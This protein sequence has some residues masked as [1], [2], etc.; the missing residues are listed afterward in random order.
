MHIK[1]KFRLTYFVITSMLLVSCSTTI[2][3][4]TGTINLADNDA[5]VNTKL[6]FEK[7]NFIADK[8]IAIGQQ[9][10]TAYGMG[11]KASA[12]NPY[13]SDM[14]DVTGKYPAVQGWDVGHI[15]LGHS[16]NLDT[17][18]FDLMRRQIIEGNRRGAIT[19]ISWHVDN[20]ETDSVAWDPT[21]AV[22]GVLK[23][24]HNRDKYL[25]WVDRLSTFMQSLKDKDGQ[26]IPIIFRP[27]H[28]MN[29]SWFWWGAGNCTPKEYKALYRDLADLLKERGNHNLIYAYSPN[30]VKSVEE[31]ATY[32]PGDD[33]VDLMGIDLYNHRGDEYFTAELKEYLGY[34]RQFAEMHNKPYAM[35]ET[36]NNKPGDPNWWTEIFYPGIENSGIIYALFWRNAWPSHYFSTFSNE[37]SS[38]NFKVFEKK[39]EILFLEDIDQYHFK[40]K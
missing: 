30:T 21:P 16:I 29:G 15:E 36:G 19:T 33:Y 18:S 5:T 23:G 25:G 39:E 8:G 32:Y 17:V 4:A 27:Y 37:I 26:A 7:M 20:P 13:R 35:T 34:A 12:E 24:G 9:D 6:L 1:N 22:T 2:P 10:A 40:A 31:Y 38:E 3:V 14:H 11:W 28:E